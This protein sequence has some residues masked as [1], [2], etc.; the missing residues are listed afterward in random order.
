MTSDVEQ[1]PPGSPPPPERTKNVFERIAGV[2]FSPAETFADIARRPDVIGPLAIILILGYIATA[3]MIPKM[4]IGAITTMQ[5]EQMRKQNPNMSEEQIEQAGRIAS[6]AAKVF[7]WLGPIVMVIWYAIVAGALLLAFRLFGGQG[8]Y[9][10]AFSTTLYAWMPLVLF[11]ILMAVVVM[12]RGTFDPTTAA[13]L[14]KSNPAFL[15]DMKEQPVLFSLLSSF[16]IFTI[17]TVALLA[18]GFATLSKTSIGKAFGIVISLWL[19]MIV[20]KLGFA[21]LGASRMKA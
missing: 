12:A 18:I 5:A 1:I 16:D 8:T 11:T 14:V 2:L 20:V 21:A 15:V 17:W 7:G 10:Q 19:C 6:A 13:T 4:D 9:K 3:L